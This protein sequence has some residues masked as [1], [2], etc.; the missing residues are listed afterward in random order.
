M[1]LDGGRIHH[2]CSNSSIIYHEYM[3]TTESFFMMNPGI[4]E[5]EG[6]RKIR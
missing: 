3:T 2:T 4:R 1:I 5:I 6:L